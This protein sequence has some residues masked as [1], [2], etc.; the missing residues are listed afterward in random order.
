M[1]VTEAREILPV[2]FKIV[3][4]GSV[5]AINSQSY[6]LVQLKEYL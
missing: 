3:D 4:Y 2:I 5:R 1:P 6:K